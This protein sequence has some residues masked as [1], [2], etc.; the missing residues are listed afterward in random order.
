VKEE[1][2]GMERESKGR[3]RGRRVNYHRR[4]KISRNISI[5]PYLLKHIYLCA[6]ITK[7]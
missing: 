7:F 3:E 6:K 1:R 4:G 5:P 2:G